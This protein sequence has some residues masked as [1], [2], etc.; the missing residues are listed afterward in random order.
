MSRGATAGEGAE[1]EKEK[2]RAGKGIFG[3]LVYRRTTSEGEGGK[4]N[5]K[6][7]L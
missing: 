2:K 5:S 3:E 6:L 7:D 1:K 4:T